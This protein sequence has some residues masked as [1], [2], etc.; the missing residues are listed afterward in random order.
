MN[1]LVAQSLALTALVLF[2]NGLL[3][4]S[5]SAGVHAEQGNTATSTPAAELDGVFD[6]HVP[7]SEAKVS[8]TRYTNLDSNLNQIVEQAQARELYNFAELARTGRLTTRNIDAS[9]SRSQTIAVTLDV[10]ESYAD[11]VASFLEANGASPRNIGADYI[12]VD[13]PIRLL[14]EASERQGVVNVR[15]SIPP[16]P[17]Q[18]TLVSGGVAAH[19]VPS[20]HAAGYKG[21]GVKVG[22]IDVGFKGFASLMGTELPS[23]VNARCDTGNG[24]TTSNLSDCTPTSRPEVARLHGTAVT[25]A[26]FDVAPRADYHIANSR[27]YGSQFD[28][29][30]WMVSEGVDVIN[31]SLGWTFDGPGDGTGYYSNGP[32]KSVD[33]AVSGGIIWVNSVGNSARSSWHGSFAD[34][35]SDTLHQFDTAGD[36]CNG[37]TISLGP[38]EG[39][40][41]QLR[42]D[43]T[44]GGASKD[45][46]LYL[47]AESGGTVS[48]S[49]A[50]ATSENGQSGDTNHIPYEVIRRSHGEIVNGKY[51][52]AVKKAEGTA[53]SWIQLLVWGASG[54]LQNYVSARSIS[55]PEESSNPG[56]LAAGAARFSSTSTI[57]DFSSRG[58]TTDNRT[59]PDIVGSDGGTSSTYGS[60]YGTSQAS[61]HVAGLAALVK[62]RF[63]D[64]TPQ[65]IANYLKSNAS[66]RD[67]VPNNTWGYG[68]AKLPSLLPATTTQGTLSSDAS[69]TS[70][71]LSSIDIGT[72]SSST[73]SY[74]AS[75][76]DSATETTVTPSLSDPDASYVIKL[77]GVEDGDGTVSLAVGENVITIEV[78]A[79]DDSTARTYTVT[80]TRAPTPGLKARFAQVPSGHDGSSEFNLRLYFSEEVDLSYRD[81]SRA[82]FRTSG[83]RVLNGHR[84]AP[85]SN[86]G[87]KVD[88][89]PD[90]EGAMIITL[91]AGL[92]CDTD[93]AVCSRDGERLSVA[94]SITVPGPAPSV[95]SASV[96]TVNEGTTAV[97]TLAAVAADTQGSDLTWSIPS[98]IGGGTDAAK[99]QITS[100]GALSFTTEKD[101][102]NPD[103]A[104]VGGTYEVTVQVSDGA[105]TDTADLQVTLTDVNEAPTADAGHD[106]DDV[107]QGVTVTLEGTGA[108]PDAGDTLL[109]AWAQSG[110]D[111]VTLSATGT[112]TTTFDTPPGLTASTT[113]TFTLTV[114][115]SGGL[116]HRD[117]VSVTVVAQPPASTTTLSDDASISAL[118]L[119]GLSLSPA[120][121][122]GT[123]TYAVDAPVDATVSTVSATTTGDGA[124]VTITPSDA[125][126]TAGNGHQVSLE[127]GEN[128][129]AVLVTA[130]DG[131]ATTSYTVTV[132]RARRWSAT[133]ANEWGDSNGWLVGAN[134]IPRYAINQL[135]HWQA[136]TFDIN[137]IDEE[138][139]WA[140]DLGMNVMRVFLHDLLY[141][142]DGTGFLDRIEQYLEVADKHGIAT[143]LVFFDDVWNPNSHLGTQP[144]PTP[145]VH[146]PGWVQSPGRTILGD[147]AAHDSLKPY[148]KGVIAR[149]DGDERVIAF[150]LYNE[151]GHPNRGTYGVDGQNIELANKS[152]YSR[153]LLEKAFHWAREIGPAQP[154]F[155]SLWSKDRF[156]G[157][158][159]GNSSDRFSAQ[160]S[161]IIGFHSYMEISAFRSS[162]ELLTD[163]SDRPV[164]VTEYLARGWN[165]FELMLP[166]LQEHGVGAINWGL[167]DGKSQTKY[168]WNTWQDPEPWDPNLWFHDVLRPS[169]IPY[170]LDEA[171]LIRQLTGTTFG[172]EMPTF[173][174]GA[175]AQRSLAENT[176]QIGT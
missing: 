93:G 71:T 60:W 2:V 54:N 38:L 101:F 47:I 119:S 52:L 125:D 25:E 109:Y 9:R 55:N 30:N 42:W 98:G 4:A 95:T 58:P 15:T 132:D 84:L 140:A 34:S 64:Y 121:A 61:P 154:V 80:V 20:W 68:F 120:F 112:A 51:C 44:W 118:S 104:K 175:E 72:F 162:V 21:E 88:A 73:E 67:T 157:W 11:V 126:G 41:A 23:T 79:E 74:V 168:S 37:V 35:D 172:N 97:A 70:L 114:T 135:E 138:L 69:L 142:Q 153:A 12:E 14:V 31:M 141:K 151:P 1:R 160:H 65:Q 57:E 134:Y 96:L 127:Y 156:T 87:W 148:L 63:P 99:F 56:M 108:D 171:A 83:G 45:L 147:L 169:C 164:V 103:D 144:T 91:P 94:V 166:T 174:E 129:I 75:V 167:V 100:V 105:L 7:S 122:S 117:E 92:A 136:D 26:L 149:F 29:V 123:E 49:D 170:D 107:A 89:V 39:F 146:N 176:G 5:H 85:P 124:T 130:E 50:V 131:V 173:D 106:Q 145:G 16:Q 150:E 3:G 133:R 48:L 102:E 36:E 62:Q 110:G 81:F 137:V 139:G 163:T 10:T 18:G 53:P 165:T 46:D 116:S 86:I 43:D 115:D 59:K 152:R 8:P 22:V 66:E 90:S 28:A 111:T 82:L 24:T 19:G 6:I 33:A 27:S 128:T 158:D 40:T 13:I 143:I 17:H 113:L 161:D 78:T 76:A 32:L 77:D 159:A 155:A